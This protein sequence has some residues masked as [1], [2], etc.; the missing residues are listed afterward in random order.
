MNINDN[1]KI[2][3]YFLFACFLYA[4]QGQSSV[5]K[6]PIEKKLIITALH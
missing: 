1:K 4:S 3:L 5:V 2:S 6:N